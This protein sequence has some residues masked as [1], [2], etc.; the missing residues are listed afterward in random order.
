MDNKDNKKIKIERPKEKSFE[1]L[2]KEVDEELAAQEVDDD[3]EDDLADWEE[4]D[5]TLSEDISVRAVMHRDAHF[6]GRFEDMFAYYSRGGKGSQTTDFDLTLIENLYDVEKNSSENLTDTYLSEAE[7][8]K[9]LH[10]LEIYENLKKAREKTGSRDKYVRLIAELI[11]SEEEYPEEVINAIVAEKEKIVPVLVELLESDYL[12]DPLFPGYGLAPLLAAQCLG[13]IG[14]KR[15]IIALFESIGHDD[16]FNEEIA[17]EALHRIGEPA[18]NFLLQV[19]KG[20]TITQDTEKAALVLDHFRE[21]PD[22]AEA[23]LNMLK[24][25][26][27]QNNILLSTYLILMCESLINNKLRDEFITILQNKELAPL[28]RRDMEAVIKAWREN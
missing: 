22:V 18:K 25:K 11:L 7:R 23:G 19:L 13:M 24:R 5:E 3:I 1:D 2:V 4:D 16:F 12:R 20:K 15:A 28:L 26:D 27:V 6:G 8:T 14:G 9:V 21:Y 17:I 10:A